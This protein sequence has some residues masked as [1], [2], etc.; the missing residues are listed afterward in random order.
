MCY[1][2]VWSVTRFIRLLFAVIYLFM[3]LL[4]PTECMNFFLLFADRLF[5]INYVWKTLRA[6]H[7]WRNQLQQLFRCQ[8]QQLR[9]NTFLC[10]IYFHIEDER[11]SK[12]TLILL[13]VMLYP[14]WDSKH[15]MWFLNVLYFFFTITYL[16]MQVHRGCNIINQC[17]EIY[18]KIIS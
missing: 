16:D 1:V 7:H 8:Y 4:I 17:R 9:Y 6:L 14:F 18:E 12:F 15:L 3:L 5:L 11:F 13:H 2:C 10:L